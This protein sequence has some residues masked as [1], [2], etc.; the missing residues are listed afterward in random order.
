MSVKIKHLSIS[1]L[2]IVIFTV[3]LY[4]ATPYLINIFLNPQKYIK[5]GN[6]FVNYSVSDFQI[7]ILSVSFY[8][9]IV[10]IG[11]IVY[12]L[13]TV[14]TR[15]QLLSDYQNK[16]LLVAKYGL[17]ELYANAPI[18]YLT[19]NSDGEICGCNKSALRFFG[20]LPEEILSKNFFAYASEEDVELGKKFFDF[21]K[22]D[23]PISKK[24][25]RIRVKDGEIKWV[26]LSIFLTKDA[27]TQDKSGLVT[28]FDISDQKQLDQAKTEF[29]SLASHQLRTPLATIKWYSEMLNS[30]QLGKLNEKQKEYI[31]KVYLVNTGMIDLVEILLNVSRIEIGTLKIEK[32]PVNVSEI[33]DSILVELASQIDKKKI[34]FKKDYN[35][36]ST[37]ID[38]DPRL[39]RIVIQNLITNAIKYNKDGGSVTVSLEK[40]FG[41]GQSSVIISDTG[42]GIPKED[43]DRIFS[44]LFRARNVK[45]V[46]SSQ[47]TGLGLY[48]VKSVVQALGGSISFKSEEN[49]GS[50]FTLGL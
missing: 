45:D 43:Q 23:V 3:P 42:L 35:S 10:L 28:V 18:P 31:D 16:D 15:A 27:F 26:S 8:T 30:N 33:I 47:S 29:V 13:A 39:L 49:V 2:I 50:T 40:G 34:M 1:L 6:F 22:S 20:V 32:Q 48:L 46:G 4:F 38:S 25:I 41:I 9:L 12:L 17:E 14:S 44:K 7:Q 21:Y 19:I 11:Y 36:T 24:E 37:I 5:L